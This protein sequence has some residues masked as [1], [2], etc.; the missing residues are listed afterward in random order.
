MSDLYRKRKE[1]WTRALS[2]GYRDKSLRELRRM[3]DIAAFWRDV[4]NIKVE[5]IEDE[6]KRRE[7]NPEEAKQLGKI[8]PMRKLKR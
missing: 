5:L 3:K 6:I 7:E 4:E 2:A 1:A 8:H